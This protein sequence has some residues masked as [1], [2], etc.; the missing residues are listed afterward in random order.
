MAEFTTFEK[1]VLDLPY[2]D[3]TE[4]PEA[5]ALRKIVDA[6]PWIAY[7]AECNFDRSVADAGI[8][9]AG[10]H[11]NFEVAVGKYHKRQNDEA[12]KKAQEKANEP[13]T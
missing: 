4:G 3:K 7:V 2:G 11:A 8:F 9:Y 6:F 13:A 10:A 5:E 1:R 12:L